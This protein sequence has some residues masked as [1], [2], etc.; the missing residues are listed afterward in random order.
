MNSTTTP[1]YRVCVIYNCLNFNYSKEM[2]TRI[3]IQIDWWAIVTEAIY[4]KSITHSHIEIKALLCSNCFLNLKSTTMLNMHVVFRSSGFSF[5]YSSLPF[6]L[7]NQT[8][9]MKSIIW[10]AYSCDRKQSDLQA[11]IDHRPI[12][13]WNRLILFQKKNDWSVGW[14]AARLIRPLIVRVRVFISRWCYERK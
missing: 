7:L 11:S 13:I 4:I 2:W 14:L 5:S 3:C 9:L 1:M 12:Y 8:K 6:L 10:Q